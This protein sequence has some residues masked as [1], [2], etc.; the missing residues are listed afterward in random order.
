MDL[1]TL[2]RLRAINTT[3]QRVLEARRIQI[4]QGI[5]DGLAL[6]EKY[7]D[8]DCGVGPRA[9]VGLTHVARTLGVIE[10]GVSALNEQD[11]DLRSQLS[12]IEAVQDRLADL[13]VEAKIERQRHR[14][15]ADMMD[16]LERQVSRLKSGVSD[17]SDGPGDGT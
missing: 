3:K 12:S 8:L 11:A 1:K 16:V 4:R 9:E 5:A 10:R 6:A 15:D 14:S 7:K 13:T 2:A 17:T